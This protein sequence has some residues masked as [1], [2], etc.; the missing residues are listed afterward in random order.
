MLRR[1]V[2]LLKSLISSLFVSEWPRGDVNSNHRDYDVMSYLDNVLDYD[3][4]IY[5]REGLRD[6]G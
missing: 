3:Y 6:E 4:N 1:I 5:W 2:K